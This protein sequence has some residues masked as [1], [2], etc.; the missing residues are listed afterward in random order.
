MLSFIKR[1]YAFFLFAAAVI[2]LFFHMFLFNYSDLLGFDAI[3]YT[4]RY[5]LAFTG[6]NNSMML[7]FPVSFFDQPF[8]SILP[9]FLALIGIGSY[10]LPYIFSILI[11]RILLMLSFLLFPSKNTSL[12]LLLGIFFALNPFTF[13]FFYRLYEL[14]GWVFFVPAFI[15]IYS[16]LKEKK[17]NMNFLLAVLFSLACA[18]SSSSPLFFLVLGSFLLITSFNDLKY[19]LVHWITAGLIAG[20]WFIPYLF[21]LNYSYVQLQAGMELQTIGIFASGLFLSS[22]LIYVLF[23]QKEKMK[24]ISSERNLLLGSIILGIL[25]LAMYFPFFQSIPVLNKPFAHAYHAFFIFVIS[26]IL[27]KTE[28]LKSILPKIDSP[29]KKFIAL[30]LIAGILFMAPKTFNQYGQDYPIIFEK[31]YVSD[32]GVIVS[33]DE[34]AQAVFSL[35]EN[36]RYFSIPY[37]SS[38]D[39]Y[40]SLQKR[41]VQ[42]ALGW[43]FNPYVRKEIFELG[44]EINKMNLSCADLIN[45]SNKLGITHFIALTKESQTYFNSCEITSP[46]NALPS[47]HASPQFA[48]IIENGE[49]VEYGNTYIKLK[50]NPPFTVL[51]MNYFPKWKIYPE[52]NF[53]D[54]SPGIKIFADKPEVIELKFEKTFIEEISFFLSL[55]ALLA[56]SFIVFLKKPEHFK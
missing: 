47:I 12:K 6:W 56:L 28:N 22:A 15:F 31:E 37:D 2:F 8:P 36:S 5:Q 23:K 44:L 11:L 46:S 48:G 14:A 18:L 17:F 42:S 41:P 4:L 19:L 35:P 55:L 1:N 43:G 52:H 9:S 24:K 54:L 39:S 50:I 20:F 13:N 30:I 34:A 21:Y 10:T 53:E 33:F 32:D 29:A 7:G 26:F 3:G 45:Y 16:F 49:I 25:I 27:L 51:K 40:V 38:L